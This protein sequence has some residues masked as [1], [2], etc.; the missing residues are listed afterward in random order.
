VS[1]PPDAPL[2]RG[3]GCFVLGVT[4]RPVVSD[5]AKRRWR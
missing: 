4:K 2:N 5:E 3:G 1:L